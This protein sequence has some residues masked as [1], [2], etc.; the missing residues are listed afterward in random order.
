M[1]VRSYDT[2]LDVQLNQHLH[3]L[4]QAERDVLWIEQRIK[5]IKRYLNTEYSTSDI[6]ASYADPER[7]TEYDRAISSIILHGN[8]KAFQSFAE[9]AIQFQAERE[10]KE[11]K[12]SQ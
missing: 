10:L 12:H 1:T 7:W 8:Y 11:L 3:K 5:H 4:D 2:Y 6:L 9:R